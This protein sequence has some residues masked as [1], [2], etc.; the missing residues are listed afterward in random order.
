[1]FDIIRHGAVRLFL[2]GGE[3]TLLFV[4]VTVFLHLWY[5]TRSVVRHRHVIARDR[6]LP[7]AR[8]DL[9]HCRQAR[10]ATQPATSALA[11]DVVRHG[12]RKYS[13]RHAQSHA[14]RLLER[15]EQLP[16]HARDGS[17]AVD[18]LVTGHPTTRGV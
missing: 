15:P 5:H 4:C 18:H 2:G 3:L 7:L 17:D 9:L 16:R 6:L 8:G 12:G 10:R 14:T 1:M 11:L 13:A